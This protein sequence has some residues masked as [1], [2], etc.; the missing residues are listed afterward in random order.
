MTKPPQPIDEA[1]L[2]QIEKDLADSFEVFR[3]A[4]GA[5]MS[6]TPASSRMA[7]SQFVTRILAFA[8][9]ENDAH[10]TQAV[11]A[12][13]KTER[14]KIDRLVALA[15]KRGYEKR[16]EDEKLVKSRGQAIT[17]EL[18]KWSKE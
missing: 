11:T 14:S 5:Y 9:R 10:I 3:R 1:E 7:A 18:E 8:K 13:L 16:I 2:E 15:E 6:G 12:A 4:E 17:N